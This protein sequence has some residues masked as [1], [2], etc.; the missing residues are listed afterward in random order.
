[1]TYQDCQKIVDATKHIFKGTK[2]GVEY[3]LDGEPYFTH[4]GE[5]AEPENLP[6]KLLKKFEAI[7]STLE[8]VY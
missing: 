7:V 3:Y 6:K 8:I 4:N 2:Y 5:I 1:M